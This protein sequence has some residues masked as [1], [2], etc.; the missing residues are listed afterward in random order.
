MSFRTFRIG[1]PCECHAVMG[2]PLESPRCA[3]AWI[4]F[5]IWQCSVRS[6]DLSREDLYLGAGY[7]QQP[8]WYR[9]VSRKTI[10]YRTS[11]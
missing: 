1:M 3:C 9:V 11:E 2:S 4:I 5:R 10:L 7:R 8:Q 6:L